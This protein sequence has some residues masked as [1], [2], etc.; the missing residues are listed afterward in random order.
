MQCFSLSKLFTGCFVLTLL[1]ASVSVLEAA[2][3]QL[4]LLGKLRASSSLIAGAGVDNVGN[5]Y[6]ANEQKALSKFDVYGRKLISYSALIS[7]DGGFAVS[8]L[9]SRMYVASGHQVFIVNGDTGVPIGQFGV[10]APEFGQVQLIGLDDRGFVF[11]ADIR[12]N[13]IRIY[14][15]L[16]NF[17]SEFNG[18]EILLSD[19]A[20]SIS[21]LAI[22]QF[23][24]EL[25]LAVEQGTEGSRESHVMV[26]DFSGKLL[27]A[28]SGKTDFGPQ[29]IG[30]F[31]S[32]AFD[33]AGRVYIL[34]GKKN[35]IRCLDLLTMDVSVYDKTNNLIC[36]K[37]DFSGLVVDP[38]TSRLF[39]YSG[40]KVVIL[41]IDGAEPPRPE[42]IQ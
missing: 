18:P 37:G 38:V 14:S 15:P 17:I 42:E 10:S 23:K 22:N 27:V 41:G 24:R 3:P 9:G 2:A 33:P 36:R 39:A 8:P 40:K 25:W 11:T 12:A 34:D 35:E 31:T 32:L 21:T 16:G 29:A 28:L 1:I 20:A 7:A 30:E 13:K 4:S 19:P 26:Y 5:F 6:L